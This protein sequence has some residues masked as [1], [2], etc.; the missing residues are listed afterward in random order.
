[1][2]KILILN[3][4][5]VFLFTKISHSPAYCLFSCKLSSI[6]SD[7]PLDPEV[8]ETEATEFRVLSAEIW[9]AG[10]SDNVISVRATSVLSVV[11][12][13]LL[14]L[15]DPWFDLDLPP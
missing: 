15:V 8:V 7:I 5:A 3:T 11:D 4:Y 6:C 12:R 1:M 10:P 9:C 14:V 13:L 2:F